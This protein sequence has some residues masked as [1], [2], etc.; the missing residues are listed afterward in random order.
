MHTV[1]VCCLVLFNV[2]MSV[3]VCVCINTRM[4]ACTCI[5]MGVG[6]CCI[7]CRLDLCL[8]PPQGISVCSSFRIALLLHHWSYFV[9]S[10]QGEGGLCCFCTIT[11][12]MMQRQGCT[13][14]PVNQTVVVQS[15]LLK[16]K[17]S[18]KMHK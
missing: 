9:G 18:P 2:F 12:L 1:P 4:P 7:C 17:C 8:S 10:W 13:H 3:C 15:M 16:A 5:A 14:P 6:V 11:E